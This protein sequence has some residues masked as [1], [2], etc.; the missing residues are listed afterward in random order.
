MK[1]LMFGWEWPPYNSGGLGVACKGLAY[2]LFKKNIGL[3]FVLP[4]KNEGIKEKFRI[5]FAG[6][7]TKNNLSAYPSKIGFYGDGLIGE[8]NQYAALAVK[9]AERESFNV[10]HAHD[11]LS[12]KAGV[13]AKKKSKK[14]LVV[15]AHATEFDRGG[16]TKINSQ[17]Y[18]IEKEGLEEA[19]KVIAVS[20]YTKNILVRNYGIQPEKIA[21]VW[22]GINPEEYTA[23]SAY[24]NFLK[25]KTDGKKLALFVGRL[26]LQK[27]PDYFVKVAKKVLEFNAK[28]IF[29][30][31]GSG[32]MQKQIINETIEAGLSD[33]IFFTGFLRG[34]EL[35]AI[36][37][38]AD[39]FVMPSVSEPFGITAL[40]AAAYGVPVLISKQSG[41]AETLKNSLKTDFWDIEEMANKILA[42]LKN[43]SL[44]KTLIANAQQ[45]IQAVTWDRAAEKCIKIYQQLTT[46]L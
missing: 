34:E 42:V 46:D 9:I 7:N 36:Y 43:N 2:A 19:D 24:K 1:V 21:V 33:K 35:E 41:V 44:K 38:T 15:H 32:D 25:I 17:V 14:P 39:V 28:V 30:I 31:V 11:W 6:V 8:V 23:S 29:A 26:T 20:N 3:S 37:K 27:G 12:F 18:D 5:I 40:E 16:G 22:N 4:K 45:E 13:A 10:I